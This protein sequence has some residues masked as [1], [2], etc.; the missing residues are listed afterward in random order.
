MLSKINGCIIIPTYNNEGT[1]SAVITRVL[2]VV[3]DS[4]I[5]VVNGRKRIKKFLRT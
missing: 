1:L 3:P 5:I 2:E 4:M